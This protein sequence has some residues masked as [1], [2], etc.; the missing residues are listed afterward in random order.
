MT[1]R[2]LA[3]L[4][5]PFVLL[6]SLWAQE[7]GKKPNILLIL[8][9]DLGVTDLTINGST[10]YETPHLDTLAKG[11]VN[12]TNAYAAHPVCSPTRAAL[13]TGKVPQRVGITQWISNNQTHLALEEV[14]I[15]EAM[16]EAGYRTG[17]IGKWHLGKASAYQPE[18]Q[19]F[20]QCIAVNRAGQPGSFFYPFTRGN[21]HPTNVPD[22]R[23]DY[24][25]GDYLTDALT[26]KA[27]D[28]VQAS[29]D[30]PFF[31]CLSHYGVHTPIQAPEEL[32]QKYEEKR[33]KLYGDSPIELANGKYDKK[34]LSRHEKPVYA[35]MME[36]LDTNIGR[37]VEALKASGQFEDTI[38]LFT[39]DNGGLT[40][41]ATWVGPTSNLPYRSGKAWTYEGGV[42][43][44]S[45]I[46]WPSRIQPATSSTRMITMD[47]YPTILDCLLYT[48]P[49]PR[50]A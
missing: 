16:Q 31:L 49:S 19:G 36:N 12:F 47:L 30:R 9:D 21:K 14:T 28:F 42:R 4:L 32:V 45:F 41:H 27:I 29:D 33:K 15:G 34:F 50:D 1:I 25:K 7:D 40:H 44:P 8:I 38:I 13:M 18:H 22:L 2:F 5:L 26:D 24:K 46:S 3:N 20:E 37:V 23:A 39:S 10:F 35:A 17:Y 48:S 43:I 11:G 6:L